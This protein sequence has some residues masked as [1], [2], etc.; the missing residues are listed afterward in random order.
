MGFVPAVQRSS[1]LAS[2]MLITEV[3]YAATTA[4]RTRSSQSEGVSARRGFKRQKSTQRLLGAHAAVYNS[5]N[6]QRHQLSRRAMRNLHARPE[7]VWSRV[8]A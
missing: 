2:A 5:I 7:F 3:G 1:N 8:V 6:I 4:P